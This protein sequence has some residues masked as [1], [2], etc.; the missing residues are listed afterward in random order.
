MASKD[1]FGGLADA[2]DGTLGRSLDDS[3]R[4][5]A[6]FEQEL[7]RLRESMLYT[8]REVGSLTSGIG[9]GL[10]R[11]FN[12]LVFDGMKLS[13]A[14]STVARSMADSAFSVAMRPIQQALAGAISQGVTGLVS[15]AMPFADGGSFSQGRVMPF[16]KGGVVSQP[17][18]FP[19][20]GATGLMGEAGPEAIMP[21]RRGADGKLGVAA[22]GGGGRAVNVTFNVSTPDVGG[23]AR[24]Q[25]QIAARFGRML[26][27][28]DRNG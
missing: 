6:A 23:F 27:R 10:R 12:G 3:G 2:G 15:G 28:G 13:D 25:S 4:V 1:G 17:T 21:L 24:S 19:M 5:T 9:S 22:A 26:A 14:L 16:A 20:R 18:Y 8:N 11:A 7:S